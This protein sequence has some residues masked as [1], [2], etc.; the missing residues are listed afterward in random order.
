MVVPG[1]PQDSE[2]PWHVTP[3]RFAQVA[4]WAA[5]SLVAIVI[6]GSLVRLTGSGLG[7][8]DWPTCE[9]GEFVP[10][11]DFHGWVEFGNRLVTGLVSVAVVAAVG[12]SL[13]RRPRRNDLAWWSLGLVAGV[14]FQVGLGA[15]TVLTHL[16]PPI[17]MSHF[18]ASQVLVAA[19][20]VLAHRAGTE[21]GSEHACAAP[22]SA[23]IRTL[24]WLA[25]ALTAAALWTGT[26]VTGTG[27][28][29]G[30]EH[31]ERLQFALPS[32]ARFHGVTVALLAGVTLL[33]G[34]T[35]RRNAARTPAR[36]TS[37]GRRG[38]EPRDAGPR[39]AERCAALARRVRIVIAVIAVQAAIGYI[40]YFN[41]LPV[42]LVALHVAGATWLTMAMTRLVLAAESGH[43]AGPETGDPASNPALSES[44]HGLDPSVLRR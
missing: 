13:W 19:A 40:Q 18:L 36:R 29:G 24:A 11:A 8:S 43:Q 28:H 10:A 37:E 41:E 27:P 2:R 31:V 25:A 12:A 35:V 32:V 6:T 5:W 44:S 42:L 22:L 1:L 14:A 38:G 23:R 21:P 26:V 9:P 3:E 20:V 34:A 17:V 15:V 39:D 33:L 30:D 16:S 7:C 4:R